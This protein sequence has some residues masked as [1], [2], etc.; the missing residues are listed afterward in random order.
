M[1]I[2]NN[3]ARQKLNNLSDRLFASL[4]RWNYFRN[5]ILVIFRDS[6]F[7]NP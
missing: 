6:I 4:Y 2:Q 1:F 5:D 7:L 3:L